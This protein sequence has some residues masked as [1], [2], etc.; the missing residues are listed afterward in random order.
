M[1]QMKT[2][3]E[4]FTVIGSHRAPTGQPI[5]LRQGDDVVVHREDTEFLTWFWCTAPDGVSGWVHA[6]YLSG[7]SG[8]SKATRDYCAAEFN[9]SGGETGRI[10]EVCGG[11]AW[12]ELADGRVG[13]IMQKLLA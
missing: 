4:T 9:L 6:G 3:G 1:H 12:A 7:A 10:L 2:A 11:W 5:T 13:W 8:P